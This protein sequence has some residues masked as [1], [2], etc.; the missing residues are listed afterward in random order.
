LFSSLSLLWLCSGS[1]SKLPSTKCLEAA[2][3]IP[4]DQPQHV[5]TIKNFSKA[6]LRFRSICSNNKGDANTIWYVWTSLGKFIDREYLLDVS[7]AYVN[8]K[9]HDTRISIFTMLNKKYV[10]FHDD[11]TDR[12]TKVVENAPSP[13]L[14]LK[15]VTEFTYYFKVTASPKSQSFAF[16]ITMPPPPN[17]R[18]LT[19][20]T[21]DPLAGETVNGTLINARENNVFNGCYDP[22]DKS[23]PAVYYNFT[24]VLSVEMFATVE[25]PKGRNLHIYVDNG[26]DYYDTPNLLDKTACGPNRFSFFAKGNTTYLIQVYSSN[27]DG[28]GDFQLNLSGSPDYF[29]LIDPKTDV[30]VGIIDEHVSYSEERTRM[31]I[32]AV[33]TDKSTKS[34]LVT[35]DNPPRS[36]CERRAP[37]SVFGN[38]KGNY[39]SK[40]HVVTATQYAASNCK[41]PVGRTTSRT[42]NVRGCEPTLYVMDQVCDV[43]DYCGTCN[44]I[45]PGM[46][47]VIPA[48]SI[49]LQA[50]FVYCDGKGFAY[51]LRDANTN[52]IVL[53]ARQSNGPYYLFGRKGRM[54]NLGSLKPGN[55]TLQLSVDGIQLQPITFSTSD[56]AECE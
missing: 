51:K 54:T 22:S 5:D 53:S 33:I 34:V 12:I 15:T 27:A 31:N 8:E 37:Y 41:G 40:T 24:N 49:V 7:A 32:Q 52:K 29:N 56:G 17:D 35:F 47:K 10:Y 25:L 21:L 9:S 2:I 43:D 3:S 42:F 19:A 46:Y 4:F 1:E 16:N 30:T 50:S 38:I 45:N 13:I 39:S 28:G 20:I 23:T 18:S 36:H 44:A 14:Q 26:D 11:E 6:A 55:Y 48:R